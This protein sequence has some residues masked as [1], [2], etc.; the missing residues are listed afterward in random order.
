MTDDNEMLYIP[1]LALITKIHHDSKGE[2]VCISH[3]RYLEDEA[4]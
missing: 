2:F 3:K 4:P 1:D